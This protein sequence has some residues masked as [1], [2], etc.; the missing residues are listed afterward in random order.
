VWLPGKANSAKAGR[1]VAART[2]WACTYRHALYGRA[3]YGR[4]SYVYLR[5]QFYLSKLPG[6]PKLQAEIA[7]LPL[8]LPVEFFSG[9]AGDQKKNLLVDSVFGRW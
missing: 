9:P 8:N 2:L 7:T 4:A 1:G 3:L 5:V 6:P